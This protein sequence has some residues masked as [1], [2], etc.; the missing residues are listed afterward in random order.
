MSAIH[1]NYFVETPGITSRLGDV[2]P[3]TRREIQRSLSKRVH[4]V[5]AS[6]KNR[7]PIPWRN[8][9]EHSLFGLLE[10]DPLVVSFE[11]MPEKVSFFLGGVQH[12]HVPTARIVT[13][14]GRAVLDAIRSTGRLADA[15]SLIYADRGI[16]YRAIDSR[17][18]HVLPRRDNAIWILSFRAFEPS[19]EQVRAVTMALADRDCRSIELLM[20]E[21]DQ[22]DVMATVCSMALDRRLAL[23]L[24]ASSPGEMRAC[25]FAGAQR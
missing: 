6:R 2:D 11:G 9:D 8:R 23:D 21:V 3:A 25:L 13:T 14:N 16:A 20:E 12:N 7:K 10:I 15:V 5:F 19:P 17:S 22:P 1:S 18:L 24:M 4:G